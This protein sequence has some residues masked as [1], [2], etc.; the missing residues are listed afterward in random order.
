M[1]NEDGTINTNKIVEIREIT[2][3]YNREF[4]SGTSSINKENINLTS[5]NSKYYKFPIVTEKMIYC[6]FDTI[7]RITVYKEDSQDFG[8][9][10]HHIQYDNW[11]NI[12]EDLSIPE[13]TNRLI[14][15][16]TYEYFYLKDFEYAERDGEK[17]VSGMTKNYS[18]PWI[19][20]TV[21]YN[22]KIVEYTERKIKN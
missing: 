3:S 12:S 8:I 17:F 16:I 18:N 2:Y 13:D 20:R 6:E 14:S 7:G 9:V 4:I 21:R 1:V 19:K 10:L 22:G 5:D 15:K 11:G